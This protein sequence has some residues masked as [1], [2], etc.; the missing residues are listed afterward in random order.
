MRAVVDAS[1]AVQWVLPEPQT[2]KAVRLRNEFRAGFHE[3]L[4]PDIFPAEVAHAL[5]RAER[6]GILRPGLSVRRLNS[7]LSD[8]PAL[9]P[10]LPLLGQAVAIS[11]ATRQG[12][13]DCLYVALALR[14]GCDLVRAD[15]KLIANLQAAYPFLMD[16]ATMP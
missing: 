7:V 3:L 1:V 13:Y 8:P 9:H 6:K 4:A 16:L 12:L 10:Y 11:S 5:T 2:P 14:E 15:R